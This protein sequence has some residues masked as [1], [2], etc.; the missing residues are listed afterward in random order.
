MARSL[1]KGPYIVASL[2]KKV[3]AMNEGKISKEDI[4]T[5]ALKRELT[6]EIDIPIVDTPTFIGF[7]ND[8]LT[9]VGSVHLGLV[10]CAQ[11]VSKSFNVVEKDKMRC[12]WVSKDFI[13]DNFEKLE[14]WSQI[15][16]SSVI[17]NENT[18]HKI[19]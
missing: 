18:E 5:E 12:E 9:E 17:K 1:K 19:A 11:A 7:I 13:N 6:E 8:D 16:F 3:T 10:F 2:E 14:T 4:I 15:L